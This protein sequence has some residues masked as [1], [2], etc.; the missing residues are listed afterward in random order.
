MLQFKHLHLS[1]EQTLEYFDI[2]RVSYVSD[3]RKCAMKNDPDLEAAGDVQPDS[4]A[5]SEAMG[6]VENILKIERVPSDDEATKKVGIVSST[7][8]GSCAA[9]DK[10]EAIQLNSYHQN[11]YRPSLDSNL[12]EQPSECSPSTSNLS[13]MTTTTFSPIQTT[14]STPNSKPDMKTEEI[15]RESEDNLY[16][17][18]ILKQM[19]ESIAIM[20]GMQTDPM[21]MYGNNETPSTSQSNIDSSMSLA[22]SRPLKR[23]HSDNIPYETTIKQKISDELKLGGVFFF[24]SI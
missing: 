15:K 17:A 23:H 11:I 8:L 6:I 13:M 21:E 12:F 19:E 10:D 22:E 14:H 1:L 24:H 5:S 9:K 18:M 4:N 16:D 20:S 3:N 7:H 2:E